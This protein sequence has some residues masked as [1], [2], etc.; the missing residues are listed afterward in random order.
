MPSIAR[1]PTGLEFSFRCYLSWRLVSLGVISG[2]DLLTFWPLWHAIKN[3][4]SGLGLVFR[5]R[6]RY[7]YALVG[8]L[9]SKTSLKRSA[10]M[11]IRENPTGSS[12]TV[13]TYISTRGLSSA[14]SSTCH[15]SGVEISKKM[16]SDVHHEDGGNRWKRGPI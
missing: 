10:L 3:R 5:G 9:Q 11:P 15:V 7:I 13:C 8:I 4:P 12:H 16:D 1:G 2:F 6:E 14:G